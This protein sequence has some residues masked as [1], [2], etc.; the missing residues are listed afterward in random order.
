MPHKRLHLVAVEY[1]RPE[2]AERAVAA[3]Q[4]LDQKHSLVLHDAAV[5]V[6]NAAG[7]VDLRQMHELA[8]G[9]SVVGGGT[10]GLLLG[11]LLGGPVGGALVGMGGGA[12]LAA[13]DRG[14]SDN[15]MRHFAEEL[16][17]G[18]AAMF[19]LVAEVDWAALGTCLLA[20][21]GE[22]VASAVDDAVAAA[23]ASGS[24]GP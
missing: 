11:L 8:A 13:F 24:A 5:A 20:Y 9:E 19:A 14:I 17:F 2:T 12:G 1:E 23:L 15:K 22:I 6:K 16:G 4:Q 3:V 18:H 10:I 7:G 21:G